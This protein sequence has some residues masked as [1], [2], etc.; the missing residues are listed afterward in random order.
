MAQPK[1][2]T[3]T[4]MIS[5]DLNDDTPVVVQP[6][7]RTAEDEAAGDEP[8]ESFDQ[9]DEEA[10][11]M[12]A[13][14]EKV[15]RPQAAPVAP[16]VEQVTK[17]E[18]PKEKELS[19]SEVRKALR[20][21][22]DRMAEILAKQPQVEITIPLDGKEKKG[23]AFHYVNCNGYEMNIA[24]GVRSIVPQQIAEMIWES[25]GFSSDVDERYNLANKD[26]EAAKAALDY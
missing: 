5:H 19:D 15:N 3:P 16:V 9:V 13:A 25:Q 2:K 10:Q 17:S 20:A 7:D 21:D 1:A 8:E 23:Q 11:E 18:K 26:D 14:E 22:R 24:K 6:I 4:P 12:E